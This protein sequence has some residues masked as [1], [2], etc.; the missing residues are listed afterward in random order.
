REGLRRF[1]NQVAARDARTINV[2]GR[3]CVN[4]ASND[5]LALRFHKALIRCA[6]EWAEAYGVGSGASRLVTGNLDLFAPIEAKVAKLKNKPWAAIMGW[7]FQPNA[8]V[9]QALFDKAV[10][11]AEPTVFTDRLN[12]ASMHF[13][14][15]AAGARELRYRHCDAK[16][17][18]ELLSQ[19][20]QD[21]RPKFI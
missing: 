1:L 12:H 6:A 16:H 2:G 8:A 11:G 19:H 5:Y 4:L 20:E 14:C 7:G 10:L 15:Q 18:G 9:L 3:C 13:G 17:L 21:E